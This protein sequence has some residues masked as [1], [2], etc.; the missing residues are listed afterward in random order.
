MKLKTVGGEAL[1]GDVLSLWL[2]DSFFRYFPLGPRPATAMVSEVTWV[3]GA[4]GG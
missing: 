3:S 4:V 2:S 1:G